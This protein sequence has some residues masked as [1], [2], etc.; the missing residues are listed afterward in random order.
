[1]GRDGFRAGRAEGINTCLDTNGF[2]RRYDP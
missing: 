2:V 1:M